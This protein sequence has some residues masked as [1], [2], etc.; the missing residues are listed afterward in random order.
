MESSE[1]A[2]RGGPSRGPSAPPLQHQQE[3]FAAGGDLAG[4]LPAWLKGQRQ[5]FFFL[6]GGGKSPEGKHHPTLAEVEGRPW[7][8]EVGVLGWR[9]T[10]RRPRG[11]E[12]LSQVL[13]SL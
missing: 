10:Q 1:K 11:S 6:M 5:G 12:D 4:T 7:G 2:P 13:G 9:V 3:G 8:R